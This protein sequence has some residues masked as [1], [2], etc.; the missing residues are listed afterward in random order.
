M[1]EE[2]LKGGRSK[3]IVVKIGNTVHR[4][5]GKNSSFVHSLLKLLE[6]KDFRYAPKFLGMDEQGREILSFIDGDVP[7]TEINWTNESLKKMAQI[8]KEFHNATVCSNLAGEKEVVCHKDIAP[9]NIVVKNGIPVGLIDFDN[10]APGNRIDDFAYFLWTFLEL[11]NDSISIKTQ[12]DKIKMLCDIYGYNNKYNLV[13]AII[14][15]QYIILK[16]RK[17]LTLNDSDQS[18]REFSASKVLQINSEINWIK[19]N[20]LSI[21][22][23]L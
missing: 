9:W 10:V 19:K 6:E 4:T 3:T 5:V 14:E 8:I 7:H 22:S 11:G 16:M 18:A 21:E 13:D 15:Q 2:I 12:V 23:A 20:R 17:E 1:K